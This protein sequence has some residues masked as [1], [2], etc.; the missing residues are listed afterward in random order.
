MANKRQLKKY[1][2]NMA[3]NLAGETVFI[4]NYYDGID[5][6]KANDVIDKIFNLLT[7]KIND[8]SVDFDKTCK[9]SFAGDRKAYDE[10]VPVNAIAATGTPEQALFT[11]AGER[12]KESISNMRTIAAAAR[13]AGMEVTELIVPGAGHD[14]HAVQAVWRPGLDW[15]GERTGLGEMTKSLKEYPQ[16]EVLQ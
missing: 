12:D 15:F 7:E 10:Q 6:A 1:M 5:E 3:A 14:W 4:L 8:V 2:K 9:D 13:K 16:V 11:G